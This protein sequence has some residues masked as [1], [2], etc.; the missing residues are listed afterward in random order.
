MVV[1]LATLQPANYE[2]VSVHVLHVC[3]NS[4]SACFVNRGGGWPCHLAACVYKIV[5]V[6]VR[7]LDVCTK[8]MG[9]CFVNRGGGW[10][11]HFAAC[12]YK[13]VCLYACL[14]CLL[15]VTAHEF[16]GLSASHS[17]I[18]VNT[19]TSTYLLLLQLLWVHGP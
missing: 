18:E 17:D 10:P 4:I 13:V 7:V 8:G 5:C 1:G 14:L 3:T 19:H 6:C 9:A 15:S 12:V 11:C 16:C 2:C